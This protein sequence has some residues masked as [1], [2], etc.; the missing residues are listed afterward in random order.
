[1]RMPKLTDL[2]GRW[3]YSDTTLQRCALGGRLL[4][5][6]CGV[7]CCGQAALLYERAVKT[8]E[9]PERHVFLAEALVLGERKDE[10]LWHYE[11][12]AGLYEDRQKKVCTSGVGYHGC[13]RQCKREA[14]QTLPA[15]FHSR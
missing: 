7:R 1:M 5:R 4:N 15:R 8:E 13:H 3:T 10:A 14:K 6:D 9:T 11:R 2:E 12:A